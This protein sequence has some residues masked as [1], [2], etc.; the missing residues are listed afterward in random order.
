MT[1]LIGV[2]DYINPPFSI[3]EEAFPE[4]EF[5]NLQC[6][7]ENSFD[8]S[9]LSKLDGML[10]WHT[11][12]T[13]K[14]AKLLNNCKILVRYG[15]GYDNVDV[16]SFSREDIIFSNT[17]DYGTEEVADT[18]CSMILGINR[19]I[20]SYDEFSRNFNSG[21]QENVQPPLLRASHT[22]VGI[23]GV[24]R[25]GAAVINRLKPFGYRILGFD[26]EQPSGHEKSIGYIRCNSLDEL[27][28]CSDIVSI[29]VPL[30]AGTKGMFNKD[31][32]YSMKKGASLVN[33][34]RGPIISSLDDIY[35]VLKSN[36]LSHAFLDVLPQEPPLFQNRL[37]KAWSSREN[38]LKG[39]LL[40]NP[41]TSYYSEQAIYEMRYKAAETLRLYIVDKFKRNVISS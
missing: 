31:R 15:V 18:A 5:I 20:Y 3:E 17:P 22:T 28:K 37:M 1:Y 32:L 27:L 11:H 38:W 14:T 40:I 29:H 39:R 21:W 35:D 8:A 41:H 13:S 6:T 23:V 9:I 16:S 10:V 24:G 19:K 2:T 36:H 34:A 30:N 25:I 12:L 26:P 7:D 33:T 4:A